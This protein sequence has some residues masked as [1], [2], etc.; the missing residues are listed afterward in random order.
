MCVRVCVYVWVCGCV[1]CGVWG[2]LG[3]LFIKNTSYNLRMVWATYLYI[4]MY[5]QDL[6]E[7]T[8]SR[9]KDVY[10][11]KDCVDAWTK[12][13]WTDCQRNGCIHTENLIGRTKCS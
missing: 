13:S 10:I 4:L 5:V 7:Y 9:I 6:L 11:Q 8:A 1:G 12:G 2:E 3:G